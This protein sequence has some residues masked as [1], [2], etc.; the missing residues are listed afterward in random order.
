MVEGFVRIDPKNCELVGVRCGSCGSEVLFKPVA[1]RAPG[2][3]LC[4]NC[5]RPLRGA[6]VV[7]NE[8]RRFQDV[9][10]QSGAIAFLIIPSK[11]VQP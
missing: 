8:F 5:S 11:L 10:K 6:D 4:P 1:Q 2:E 9:V 3:V 7:A